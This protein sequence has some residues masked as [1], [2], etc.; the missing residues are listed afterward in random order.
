MRPWCVGE[1][2]TAMDRGVEGIR[3]LLPGFRHPDE[4]FIDVYQSYAGDLSVLSSRGIGISKVQ[5]AIRWACGLPWVKVP[6]SLNTVKMHGLVEEMTGC[7]RMEEQKDVRLTLSLRTNSTNPI[8]K[9]VV[10]VGSAD[11]MF[12]G[13][14]LMENAVSAVRREVGHRNYIVCDELNFEATCTS[15]ILARLLYPFFAHVPEELPKALGT[16]EPLPPTAKKVILVCTNG[17]LE[18]ENVLATLSRGLGAAAQFL[19]VL[20]DDDFR[21]PTACFA[22]EHAEMLQEVAGTVSGATALG[23]AVGDIFKIVALPF[24]SIIGP[25]RRRDRAGTEQ[26]S[27]RDRRAAAAQREAPARAPQSP[28]G[29]RSAGEAAVRCNEPQEQPKRAH[30]CQHDSVPSS[31]ARRLWPFGPWRSA[32]PRQRLGGEGACWAVRPGGSARRASATP[33][34]SSLSGQGVGP[35]MGDTGSPSLTA[36]GADSCSPNAEAGECTPQRGP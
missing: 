19:P 35:T 26:P 27:A 4:E 7:M 9:G 36:A 13:P 33:A 12:R 32:I 28:G 34:A 3:L 30:A 1:L 17:A 23:E 2:A 31:V 10:S 8:S 16:A 14:T 18:Q 24:H 29:H 15:M 25:F 6:A 22:R 5:D 11:R 21:F 20:L